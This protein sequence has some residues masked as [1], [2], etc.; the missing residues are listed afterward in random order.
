[1][2]KRK[3]VKPALIALDDVAPVCGASCGWGDNPSVIPYCPSGSTATGNCISNGGSAG[4]TCRTAGN[5]PDTAWRRMTAP[6]M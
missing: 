3:Y 5:V 2:E 4:Q 1:M 6:K